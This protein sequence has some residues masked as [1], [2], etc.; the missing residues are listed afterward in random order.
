ML[1]GPA[2]VFPAGT[3]KLF[4]VVNWLAIVGTLCGLGLGLAVSIKN[5]LLPRRVV[6]VG[7]TAI[8]VVWGTRTALLIYYGRKGRAFRKR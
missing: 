2:Y 8:A 6:D 3:P 4:R 1:R 5:D 7:V